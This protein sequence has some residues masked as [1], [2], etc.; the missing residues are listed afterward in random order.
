MLVYFLIIGSFSGL[1]S[2]T[3]F[4]QRVNYTID[5]TL[6]D[7]LH[8]LKAFA[9][10]EY[11]NNSPDT[12]RFIY[13]HLWPNAYSANNTPLAKQL[14][15]AKG[16]QK[17]FDDSELNGFID[18]LNFKINDRSATW[19]FLSN[20][21]DVCQ[22]L[23]NTPLFPHQTILITTPFRVKI[24]KGV[25][26]RLGHIGQTYQISQWF[27]KPA[28]Y[29]SN[30]WHPMS[31]LDQGEFYSEFGSFDVNITLAQNY[32]V[33]ATGNLQ[34]IQE[35]EMLD[36]LA[37][38]TTWRDIKM[39]GKT[40]KINSSSKTKTLH[41]KGENMH[42]FA[43]FANKE[44]NVMKGSVTLPHSQKEV[45]TWVMFTSKQAR[46]WRNSLRYTNDAIVA[47]S[48]LIGDYPY[49]GFTVVQ[50]PLSAGLGMEYPGLA[51]IGTTKDSYSLDRVITH[52]AVHSWLYGA[53]GF[54]ERRYPFLDEGITSNYEN[55][56]ITT[57]YPDKKLW[58]IFLKNEKQAQFFH[59]EKIPI[60][61]MQEL[62]WLITARNNSEQPINLSS[63]EFSRMNY[64]L[65]TY[66]KSSMGFDYLRAYLGDSV[67]DSAMTDFYRL[68]KFRHPQPQDL[69]TVFQLHTDKNLNWFFDD[70]IGTTKRLDYKIVRLEKQKPLVK[71]DG[72]MTSPLIIAGLI[73][74]SISFEKWVDGFSGEKWIELPQ[75]NY[76]EIKID[77]NHVMPELFRLNN[78]IKTSGMFPKADPIVTQLLFTV[79]DIEKRNLMYI[80]VINWT[81]YDGFMIG[82]A[83]HNG[84]LIPKPL[85]YFIMPFYAFKSNSLAGYGR[86]AYN[87]TPYDNFIRK[88]TF[89]LEGI[90]F[91]APGNQNYQKIMAGIDINFRANT[92]ITPFRQKVY[93][94]YIAASD[95]HHIHTGVHATMNLYMQ[96]GYSLKKT[97]LINPYHVLA[98][99]ETN[100]HFQK[101]AVNFNYL[102]SY[103]GR[104]NG[105]EI[106]G[107]VGTMLKNTS[108]V[109]FYSLAPSGRSGRELYL[110]EGVFPDRFA[111]FPETF[112]SRQ[113]TL[114]EGGLVSPVNE[115]LGYSQWLAS[116]SVTSSLPGMLAKTGIKPFVNVLLNDHG[117]SSSYKSVF[118]GEVGFKVGIMNIFEIYVPLLVTANIYSVNKSIKDRIRVVINLNFSE[119]LKLGLE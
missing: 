59:L 11:T 110:Y 75:G 117:L 67:Y 94:R 113:M 93:A 1:F 3:Y 29:D 87:I 35:L 55:R 98:S 63:E 38:D 27:P 16:K 92:A 58:E 37:A 114:S 20:Q 74:D 64:S 77:P 21:P 25:T 15:H 119:Q 99:L 71:N 73:G 118:F 105:L 91:G 13:F 53:L 109:P 12:L 84:V 96:F 72:E 34:N 46:L 6:D 80:P 76:T 30:G 33:A 78:N 106:R 88:A 7:T 52:E 49:P 86:I 65:M 111:I 4:Q 102:Q 82:M 79:E 26:S 43:W 31:Y 60:K 61:R 107:F 39:I 24:P 8:E 81:N 85:E 10:I 45:T 100:K 56:H 51:V 18:S 23:L 68:W 69:R 9:K 116:L 44:F 32:I 36:S 14:N 2:Q 108:S 90:Q 104:G 17:L 57:K 83:F 42:D 19:N 112:W 97:G 101:A 66:N 5:V 54:N 115:Y 41:Y 62:E 47:L 28:V 40:K 89:S 95:L 103:S 22:V 48:N 50:S 70:F